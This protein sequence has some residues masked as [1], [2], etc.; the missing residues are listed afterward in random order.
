[1]RLILSLLLTTG[2]VVQAG[3]QQANWAPD[4]TQQQTYTWHQA[5]SAESTGATL[6]YRIVSPGETLTV[7]DADGPGAI[8]TFGFRLAA[9]EP[10]HLKRI[11]LRMYWDGVERVSS[12]VFNL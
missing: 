1:M 8:A 3:A 10:Y 5:S 7:L 6:D 12:V 9:P 11:V 4:L 2:L